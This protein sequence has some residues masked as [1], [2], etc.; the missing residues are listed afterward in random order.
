MEKHQGYILDVNYTKVNI[1]DVVD[2]LDIQR[3]SKR[4]LKE[5]LKKYPRLFGG[6]LGLLDMEHISIKLKEG[7]KQ[8]QGRY[9][10]ILKAC[11]Q[12]TRK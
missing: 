6:G 3:S 4:S 7:S 11:E 8:Y 9:Y 12:P 5:T 10:N 2:S 1:D